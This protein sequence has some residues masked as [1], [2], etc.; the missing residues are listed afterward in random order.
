MRQMGMTNDAKA[1]LIR[2]LSSA[3]MNY[4]KDDPL[5]ANALDGLAQLYGDMENVK[6]AEELFLEA[7]FIDR[8]NAAQPRRE[9]GIHLYHYALFLRSAGRLNEAK[10]QIELAIVTLSKS[11]GAEHPRTRMAKTSL[12]ELVELL[13][14]ST[15][16]P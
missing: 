5:V 1:Y 6:M 15:T 9:Y 14:K 10:A 7:L 16:R 3:Q 12:V 8:G 13:N 11:I 2:A 4:P